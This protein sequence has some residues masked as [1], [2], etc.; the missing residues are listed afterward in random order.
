VSYFDPDPE[1]WFLSD[2]QN[3]YTKLQLFTSGNLVE[4]LVDGANYMRSFGAL[5][6]STESGDSVYYAGWHLA[7][8]QQLESGKP[9]TSIESLMAN[10]RNRDVGI[11]VLLSGHSWNENAAI[12][13]Y[14]NKMGISCIRDKKRPRYGSTHQ[15]FSIIDRK[16]GMDAFC[17]GMDIAPDRFDYSDHSSGGWHDVQ[18]HIRGPACNDLRTTFLER[19]NDAVPANYR[20]ASMI[21]STQVGVDQP[22][23]GSHYVQVLRTYACGNGYSFAPRG[24]FSAFKACLKAISLARKYIYIE[25]QY[26]VSHELAD[27][28]A[29]GLT[30]NPELHVIVVVPRRPNFFLRVFYKHQHKIIEQLRK[31]APDRFA[32]FHLDNVSPN[33][34]GNQTYVHSKLM[35]IDDTWAAIGSMNFNRRSTTY[36]AE[37]SI[38]AVDADTEQ[39]ACRFARDLR[40]KLWSEHLKLDSNSG[41]IADPEEGFGI[42]LKRAECPDVPASFHRTPKPVNTTLF[43]P[44]WNTVHRFGWKVIDPLG[45]CVDHREA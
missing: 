8:G 35:V 36:D 43:D 4:A 26:F 6:N 3:P 25:D 40:I 22:E 32:I 21:P 11:N 45:T 41:L 28:L 1:R 10:A 17:G 34:A 42:W 12:T 16:S 13:K 27:A 23:A 39:D 37:A 19:W 29:S 44:L 7:P 24:E 38:A 9:E 31:A 30:L 18:C 15:K 14:L 20:I 2:R 33:H 5:L